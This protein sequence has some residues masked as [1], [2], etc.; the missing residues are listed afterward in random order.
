MNP[1]IA[2]PYLTEGVLPKRIVAFL[3]DFCAVCAIAAVF[4][5]LFGVFSIL[6]LGLGIH[7]FA[8]MP[9]IPFLYNWLTLGRFGA[10]PGQAAMG[11][12]VRRAADL[13]P[14]TWVEALAS[15]VCFYAT[16]AL[17]GLLLLV[18]LATDGH[19]TLHD[20]AAGL[21]VVRTDALAQ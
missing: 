7:L 15:V 12:A 10:T 1:T 4:A 21:I 13:F 9:I 8:L 3:I 11:L 18:A 6:T 16:L 19:R 14:P 2:R 5:I 17:T 20:L